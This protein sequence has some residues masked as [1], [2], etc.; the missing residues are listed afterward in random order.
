MSKHIPK[1]WGGDDTAVMTQECIAEATFN[2]AS[3]ISETDEKEGLLIISNNPEYDLSTTLDDKHTSVFWSTAE[4]PKKN[5]RKPTNRKSETL[6]G[7]FSYDGSSYKINNNHGQSGL[8]VE[9]LESIIDQFH[10]ALKNWKRVLVVRF[11]LHQPDKTRDSK[12]VAN[13]LKRLKTR[14]KREYGFDQIGHTWAREYHRK[15]KGQ[16]YHRKGKGQHYHCALFLDGSIVR[17]SSKIN[18]FIRYAWLYPIG[19]CSMGKIKKPYYFVNDENVS[20]KAIYRLSYLAKTRG[21]GMRENQA[22]DFQCSRLKPT[23]KKR[24]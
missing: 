23:K 15:G 17:H 14:L 20:Q 3:V 2:M 12:R 16:H 13:F 5:N 9:I 21:K 24:P 8:Y 6:E 19:D 1:E 18:E 11:E 4:P 10:I 22:K 7:E